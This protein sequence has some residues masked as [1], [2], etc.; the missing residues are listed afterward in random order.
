M[1]HWV[2]TASFFVALIGPSSADGKPKKRY[3]KC[4]EMCF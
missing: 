2:A 1:V 4:P 3:V